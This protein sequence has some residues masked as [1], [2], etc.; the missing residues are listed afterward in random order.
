MK[1]KKTTSH[2][3]H[4]WSFDGGMSPVGGETALWAAVITQA[5]MDALSKAKN[6]EAQYHK[7]EAIRWLTNNNADFI[8]VCLCAGFDP[9]YVRKRAKQA[10]ANPLP[11]RAEPGKGKRYHQRRKYR[12]I[13][14]LKQ[15]KNNTPSS[16][17]MVTTTLMLHMTEVAS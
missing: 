4:P 2:S 13:Y 17:A 8:T 7:H 3:S 6:S 1:T 9:D 16:T 12:H 15:Q 11:W 10:I 14:K 5:L